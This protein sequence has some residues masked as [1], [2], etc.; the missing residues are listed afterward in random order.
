[1]QKIIL[2]AMKEGNRAGQLDY[3]EKKL[4]CQAITILHQNI[5][6]PV[7]SAK[8]LESTINK[9]LKLMKLSVKTME[10]TLL[11]NKVRLLIEKTIFM[12]GNL[13]M[14]TYLKNEYSFSIF[15]IVNSIG[16]IWFIAMDYESIAAVFKLQ[17]RN[18]EELQVRRKKTLAPANT[19]K[20]FFTAFAS[21]GLII[22][23]SMIAV[24]YLLQAI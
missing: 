23:I 11:K 19:V 10:K 7:A 6:S 9:Q 13:A 22:N 20:K 3:I 18:L 8:N 16:V 4:P 5:L 12:V 2:S 14:Y 1:M 15:I 17:E 24:Q 21:L